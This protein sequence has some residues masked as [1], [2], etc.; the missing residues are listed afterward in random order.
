M[1]SG[2]GDLE[3]ETP[4]ALVCIFQKDVNGCRG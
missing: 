2:R 3:K 4:R 1:S